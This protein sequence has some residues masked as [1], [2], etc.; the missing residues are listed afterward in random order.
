[1]DVIHHAQDRPAFFKEAFRVLAGGGWLVTITDSEEIIR[2]A[3]AA[4]A[5]F[6]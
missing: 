4:V 3:R 1:V 5:L 2:R 6:S